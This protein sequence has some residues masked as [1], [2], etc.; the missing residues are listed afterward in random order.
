[1]K[2]KGAL[3][4][5]LWIKEFKMVDLIWRI[6]SKI[7]VLLYTAELLFHD[8]R[9]KL[10]T[11]KMR[12]MLEF[13]YETIYILFCKSFHQRTTTNGQAVRI[14]NV[15]NNPCANREN[16]QWSMSF[17]WQFVSVIS[18]LLN[19]NHG[20]SF[21]FVWFLFCICIGNIVIIN[22]GPNL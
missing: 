19:R 2:I 21:L 11:D 10:F 4:N 8:E 22:Y 18:N 5:K 9:T 15:K 1:M 6:Y 3:L 7:C 14:S 12:S 17:L 20:R 16:Q 13:V